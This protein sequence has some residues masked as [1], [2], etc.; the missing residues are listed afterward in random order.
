M[1]FFAFFVYVTLISGF[2]WARF[3]YFERHSPESL[4]GTFLYDPVVVGHILVSL[5]YFSEQPT[6]QAS[7]LLIAVIIL[8][9]AFM[10]FWWAVAQSYG[11]GFAGSSGS[12]R[13]VSSG[14][15]KFVRHPFYISYTLTWLG[16]CILFNSFLL[17]ITL[18]YLAA[19]YV[20]AAIKEEKQ[21]VSGN[22]DLY[23]AYQKNVGMFIPR[24]IK[25]K[26]K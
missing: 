2:V 24:I 15:F 5:W 14:P 13:I 10:V 17:W 9:L 20:T 23:S 11:L 7:F 26:K 19:F 3:Y 25:W 12:T 1:L 21:L 8:I 6:V 22:M 16:A 4:L 18:L